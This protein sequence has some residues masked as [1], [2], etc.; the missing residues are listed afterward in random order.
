MAF[1]GY[2]VVLEESSESAQGLRERYGILEVDERIGSYWV[3]GSEANILP[4]FIF[5]SDDIR[6]EF[7]DYAYE[8]YHN[9]T[10]EDSDEC[11]YLLMDALIR[12]YVE[13]SG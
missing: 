1:N 12:N 4:E 3:C 11:A 7:F 6:H 9:V 13:W 5:K 10:G 2:S 8:K